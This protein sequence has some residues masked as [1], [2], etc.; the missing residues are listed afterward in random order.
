[1]VAKRAACTGR[2]ELDV[3]LGL[4]DLGRTRRLSARMP[5]T[6]GVHSNY[7]NPALRRLTIDDGTR[8]HDLRHTFASLMLADKFRPYGVNLRCALHELT[9]IVT[10]KPWG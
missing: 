9:D 4:R 6:A 3:L 1:M 7:L 10:R 5:D 2:H 8:F